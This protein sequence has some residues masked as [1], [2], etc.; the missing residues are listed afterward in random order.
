M[1]S[2]KKGGSAFAE[3][4]R[5]KALGGNPVPAKEEETTAINWILESLFRFKMGFF[6]VSAI[7][8]LG[9]LL[10]HRTA[11]GSIFENVVFYCDGLLFLNLYHHN[12]VRFIH[13]F[14]VCIC[15]KDLIRSNE[16][17]R[18]H[19]LKIIEKQITRRRYFVYVLC[20]LGILFSLVALMME[21][22]NFSGVN[23]KLTEIIKVLVA[24]ASLGLQVW[25]IRFYK[26]TKSSKFTLDDNALFE[27]IEGFLEERSFS[28]DNIALYPEVSFRLESRY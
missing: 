15:V 27:P 19:M 14:S 12:Y 7:Y 9:H 10:Y 24:A 8:H 6:L 3:D 28:N 5:R 22:R 18:P 25:L 1:V 26:T 13:R 17:P 21:I 23:L 2:A 4:L 20:C 16:D 11:S